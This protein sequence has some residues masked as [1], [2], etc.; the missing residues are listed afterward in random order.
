MDVLPQQ[1]CGEDDLRIQAGAPMAYQNLKVLPR[2]RFEDVEAV[3]AEVDAGVAHGDPVAGE[4]E[5]HL[6]PDLL[7]EPAPGGGGGGPAVEVVLVAEELEELDPLWPR[8]D[9]LHLL[10]EEVGDVIPVL[11]LFFLIVGD[12]GGGGGVGVAPGADALKGLV[13]VGEFAGAVT[14]DGVDL[15]EDE[16]EAGGEVGSGVRRGGG[17]GGEVSEEDVV[18][19][20]V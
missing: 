1:L 9:H 2:Q 12:G 3:A 17:S 13:L 15:V 6:L 20:V 8:V 10:L 14:V 16:G 7:R 5:A 11:L 19:M 18:V 4:V